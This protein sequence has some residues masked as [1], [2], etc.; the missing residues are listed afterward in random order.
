MKKFNYTNNGREIEIEICN[1]FE[2]MRGRLY[3]GQAE[4]YVD[5]T[6]GFKREC[7]ETYEL[8]I[9]PT[10]DEDGDIVGLNGSDAQDDYDL[11]PKFVD[12]AELISDMDALLHEYEANQNMEPF[13]DA[14][15]KH[16]A[17]A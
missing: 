1:F 8:Y 3:M 10:I 16:K 7:G 17:M 12:E 15:K 14:V 5:F 4:G 2:D 6:I 13:A 9:Q 11:L